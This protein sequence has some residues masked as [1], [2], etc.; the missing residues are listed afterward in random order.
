MKKI[1][2]ILILVSIL[3]LPITFAEAST[4]SPLSFN[5]LSPSSLSGTAGDFVTVQS[6]ITNTG[7]TSLSEITSYLSLVDTE[8][9][10]PVDLEDWSAEK[11]LFIGTIEPKQTLPLN[12]KIHF[13]KAGKYSLIVVAEIAGKNYPQTSTIVNFSVGPKQNLNPGKVLPVALFTPIVILFVMVLLTYK[14]NSKLS[15]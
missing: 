5:I 12:W 13:V 15:E 3:F 6:Q 8:N 14:R 9:K 4:N 7:T 10:L 11:G 2:K 1:H